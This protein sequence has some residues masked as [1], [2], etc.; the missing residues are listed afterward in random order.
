MHVDIEHHMHDTAAKI[1]A[2]QFQLLLPL[3]ADWHGLC[4]V[5]RRNK[6]LSIRACG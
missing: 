1:A 6:S 3:L 5:S 2:C 4:E